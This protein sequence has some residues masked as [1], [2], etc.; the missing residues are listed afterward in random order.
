MPFRQTTCY[1]RS[2][3]L[4]Y[5]EAS[6]SYA[7]KVAI[8]TAATT[9]TFTHKGEN[10]HN[11][12]RRKGDLLS[13]AIQFPRKRKRRPHIFAPG[14]KDLDV[15]GNSPNHN[16]SNVKYARRW[17]ASFVQSIMFDSERGSFAADLFDFQIRAGLVWGRVWSWNGNGCGKNKRRG[18]CIGNEGTASSFVKELLSL[19]TLQHVFAR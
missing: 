2:N 14:S 15:G 9:P 19:P 11:F 1:S 17:L 12:D 18:K 4:Q 16:N 8:R 6:I 3:F 7:Y 5:F 13:I 10:K